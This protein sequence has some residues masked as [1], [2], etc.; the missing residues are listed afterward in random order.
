MS[1]GLCRADLDLLRSIEQAGSELAGA[2]RAGRRNWYLPAALAATL[3]L[4]VGVGRLVMAPQRDSDVVRGGPES[5]AVSLLQ[6]PAT[7]K[8]GTPLLFAWRPVAGALGYHLEVLNADGAV[9]LE[10]ETTDTGVVLE[11]ATAL[12]PGSYQWWVSARVPGATRRSDLRPLRLT[13]K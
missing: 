10:S 2:G 5:G 6:P 8:A 13:P 7:G 11:G 9:V 4:A 12:A 3:L 1:C